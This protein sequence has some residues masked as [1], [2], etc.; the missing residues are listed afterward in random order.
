MRM[1][2]I[3]IL[4]RALRTIPRTLGKKPKELEIREMIEIILMTALLKIL[5]RVLE[6]YCHS[7]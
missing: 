4:F 6:T 3:P 2:V 1:K 5:K 7:D